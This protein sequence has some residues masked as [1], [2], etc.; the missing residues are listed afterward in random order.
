MLNNGNTGAG[1]AFRHA[2][3]G[4]RFGRR[5]QLGLAP[6]GGLPH[7]RVPQAEDRPHAVARREFP[8][9][10]R[11]ETGRHVPGG[12]GKAVRGTGRVVPPDGA[13]AHR[14]ALSRS[15][16]KSRRLLHG[17]G[18]PDLRH[19]AGRAGLVHGAALLFSRRQKYERYRVGFFGGCVRYVRLGAY[20]ASRVYLPLRFRSGMDF[21]RAFN[22]NGAFL[23]FRSAAPSQICDKS[24]RRYY[25]PAVFIQQI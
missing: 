16:G 23:D 2:D 17:G 4:V 19:P 13:G 11:A 10:C 12:S 14:R 22:R 3:R 1:Q 9:Q 5:L 25:Y 8:A 6:G 24:G 15:D 7:A 18:R 20:G 21:R